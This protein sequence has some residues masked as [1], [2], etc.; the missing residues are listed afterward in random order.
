MPIFKMLSNK[1]VKILHNKLY[2]YITLLLS[3]FL[4]IVGFLY[5]LLSVK[6]KF[7][8]QI[9]KPLTSQIYLLNN[10][11]TLTFKGSVI[12]LKDYF[13]SFF[14]TY[15]WGHSYYDKFYYLIFFVLLF[16]VT[17]IGPFLIKFKKKDLY[18][19][20]PSLHLT[21]I[22]LILIQFVVTLAISANKGDAMWTFTQIRMSAPATFVF[23]L[24]PIVFVYN[25]L[26]RKKYIGKLETVI[27]SHFIVLSCYY[28]PK[29]FVSDI[30]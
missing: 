28:F 4:S 16:V 19:I 21:V 5:V 6:V 3:Y 20:I 9:L 7:L 13:K 10:L 27:Y 14:G 22:P 17:I 23:C 24:I 1:V 12:I 8:I 15:I 11:S 2:F 25:C 29:F 30:F 26:E 18:K